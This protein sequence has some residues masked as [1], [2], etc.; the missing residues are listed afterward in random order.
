M[1]PAAPGVILEF[2]LRFLATCCNTREGPLASCRTKGNTKPK[3]CHGDRCGSVEG[4]LRLPPAAAAVSSISAS[5]QTARRFAQRD[6]CICRRSVCW[7]WPCPIRSPAWRSIAV[8]QST[9][10]GRADSNP[11]LSMASIRALK[12]PTAASAH[13]QKIKGRRKLK[14]ESRTQGFGGKVTRKMGGRG[15]GLV[16]QRQIHLGTAASDLRPALKR[17]KPR[18]QSAEA[19][20]GS[21]PLGRGATP[22]SCL[23]PAG[24]PN[25]GTNNKRNHRKSC[26]ALAETTS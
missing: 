20:A 6:N 14:G 25:W 5:S 16:H 12:V 17:Q 4:L 8:H 9:A 1:S 7:L 19:S 11:R 23:R 10:R 13:T 21:P 24:G 2:P 3:R 22:P 15:E 18:L 26:A